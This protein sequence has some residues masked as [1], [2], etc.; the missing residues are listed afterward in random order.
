MNKWVSSIPEGRMKWVSSIPEGRMKWVSSIPEGRMKWAFLREM[1]PVYVTV[2]KYPCLRR[3][4]S[5]ATPRGQ[6]ERRNEDVTPPRGCSGSLPWCTETTEL[7]SRRWRRCFRY[8]E[9][10]VDSQPGNK[11]EVEVPFLGREGS[12]ECPLMGRG[13]RSFIGLLLQR[14]AHVVLQRRVSGQHYRQR[15][16]APR[17]AGCDLGDLSSTAGRCLI[18]L[19]LSPR[20]PPVRSW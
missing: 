2:L 10:S 18:G 16:G 19:R 11:S 9:L 17:N 14:F 13:M 6:R 15:A 4:S 7:L 3:V 8:A 1:W 12:L 5:R 20:P